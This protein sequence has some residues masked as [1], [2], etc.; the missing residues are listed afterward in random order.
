MTATSSSTGN[1]AGATS[2]PTG[3]AVAMNGG[4]TGSGRQTRITGLNQRHRGE[5]AH[6]ALD[7]RFKRRLV[8]GFNDNLETGV[9]YQTISVTL[10]GDEETPSFP[11]LSSF[12]LC[13]A[14]KRLPPRPTYV[15]HRLAGTSTRKGIMKAKTILLAMALSASSALSALAADVYPP[16]QPEVQQFS[17]TGF[18]AGGAGGWTIDGHADYQIPQAKDLG[19]DHELGGPLLGGQLGYI[20]QIGWLAGGI[21]LQGLWTDIEGDKILYDGLVDTETEIDALA[22]GKLKLGAAFDRFF[23]FGTGGYAGGQVEAHADAKYC[24]GNGCSSHWSDSDWA[25]G[26]FYGVGANVALTERWMFGI[27]WN[28]IVLNDADFDSN[29]KGGRYDGMPLQAHSDIDV[30]VILATAG[31]RF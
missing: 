21:E 23:V 29:V 19:L 12:L 15:N 10:W 2:R 31:F 1:S 25:N 17:W 11:H 5:T 27:E 14:V 16:Y 8:G 22:L 30:D 26:Y 20:Q 28:H 18:Y 9:V 13:V 6:E 3:T 7:Q 4:P 24:Q